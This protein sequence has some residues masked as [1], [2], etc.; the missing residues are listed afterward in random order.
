M[1]SIQCDLKINSDIR[2]IFMGWMEI[3]NDR[4]MQAFKHF[5]WMWFDSK[6]QRWNKIINHLF[7]LSIK[8]DMLYKAIMEL[9]VLL[10]DF[11]G[12][13]SDHTFCLESYCMLCTVHTFTAARV[14]HTIVQRV[15]FSVA[16]LA[17]QIDLKFTVQ[18]K[19]KI[20]EVSSRKMH[21]FDW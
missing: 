6:Q 3:W 16:F 12:G 9:M 14:F 17:K 7:A 19:I 1:P 20:S 15:I 4:T 5:I 21:F 18:K 2:R 10:V 13:I 8:C 11:L